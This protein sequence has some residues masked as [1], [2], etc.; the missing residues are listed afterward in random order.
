MSAVLAGSF[1]GAAGGIFKV[2]ATAPSAG[3]RP[4]EICHIL[5]AVSN[6]K[7]SVQSH[8]AELP[9]GLC[10]RCTFRPQHTGT[11]TNTYG[12]PGC[13]L[14]Q[15]TCVCKATDVHT[16]SSCEASAWLAFCLLLLQKPAVVLKCRGGNLTMLQSVWC[17]SD[18]H[19]PFPRGCRSHAWS[20]PRR[21][22]Q[23]RKLVP[24]DA[25]RNFADATLPPAR[26]SQFD[27]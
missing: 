2:H 7:S 1:S 17:S 26:K 12:G 16:L 6:D 23:S 18:Y 9:S 13:L 27:E 21:C 25:L 14:H 24:Q 8:E 15:H 10:T 11:A 22:E 5:W 3:V 20:V 4:A 19:P